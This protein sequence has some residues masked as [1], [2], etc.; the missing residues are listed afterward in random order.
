MQLPP[1][2]CWDLHNRRDFIMKQFTKTSPRAKG[3]ITGAFYL[4]FKSTFIPRPIGVL[5][6]ITGL[7]WLKFFIPPI[8]VYLLPYNSIAGAIGEASM[9]LWLLVMGVNSQRWKEQASAAGASIRT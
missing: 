7:G 5:M 2:E 8:A 6:G 4:A 1:S 9:I 3:R